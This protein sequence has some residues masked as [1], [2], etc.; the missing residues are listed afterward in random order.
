MPSENT[1]YFYPGRGGH[2]HDGNNSSF[3]D[4]SVYSLFDFS[5]GEVGDPDRVASQ[6][7]N[8]NAFRDFVITTVNGSILEPSGLVLQPGMV[9]GS[10]HIISRSIEANTI[11]ANTLTA[12]EISANTITSNELVANFVLVNTIIA[13]SDF[14]G[15]FDANTF[16]LSNTG[17]DGWAITSAGDA[18]F[19]NGLFRG[20]LFVGAND[21]WYSNG[22]FALGGNTGIYRNAGGGITLGANVSILGGVIATSVATP[23]IDIDA[24]GNLTAN[25]FALYGNGAIVTSSGNFSVD[26]SG[27]LSAENALI[28]GEL[29]SDTFVTHNRRG[30]DQPF[31]TVPT[32]LIDNNNNELAL[33]ST[34]GGFLLS[35]NRLERYSTGTDIYDLYFDFV[36]LNYDFGLGTVDALNIDGFTTTTWNLDVGGP[37]ITYG[38]SN[39]GGGFPIAFGYDNGSGQLRAIVNNDTNVYFN[40]T[41]TAVSDRR[42]KD[43]IEPISDS[44]LDR[45]YSIKIYEFDW[46]D[47]TPQSMKYTGRGVGV[48]ADELKTLYPDTVDDSEAYE[49]WVHRYDEHPEGFSV[50]EMNKF[51]SDYYEFV[52]G[53][54]VWKKPRYASVDYTTLIPHLISAVHALNNRVKELENEV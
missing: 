24:N 13:S 17:T 45:F 53:E 32:V 52:P 6:R 18:V 41:K 2:S 51:G 49:G 25:T 20:N 19:T 37:G 43:N 7:I 10:A 44:V 23:G 48:I 15:T 40:L 42:L 54:G 1:I 22:D 26:A 12:N 34:D 31:Y 36:N 9:N 4:T 3:I 14:N 39:L 29:S 30:I 35:A 33:N 28:R 27:N 47:K 8:Y 16:T 38:A 50:E 21:Y 46:N 5:W 11:A